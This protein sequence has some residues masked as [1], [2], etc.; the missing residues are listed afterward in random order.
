MASAVKAK[1]QRVASGGFSGSNNP[2]AD[3]VETEKYKLMIT[4]GPSYD[5]ALH[6]VVRV[7]TDV[8]VYVENE[9]V[10]AKINVR[11][12][13]FHGLPSSSPQTSPYFNDPTHDKD[14]YSIGFSF[15]PKQD[16][17]SLDTVWGN[18]FDHPIRN[19]LPPGFNTA[20]RIVKEFVDP[21]LSCDA[22]ADEPWLYGP[23]L[24]CWFAMRIGDHYDEDTDFPAPADK[25][26]L[27]EGA[28][29]SG[30]D[31]RRKHGL[32]DTNEKRR[33]HFLSAQHRESFV[34]EKGRLYEGDFYNPYLD[35]PNFAL[36][37]PGFSLKVI[38]Y[39]D[40]KSH[41][42][43][44]VFKNRK[45]GD[46]YFNINFHLLWGD[47]LRQAVQEDEE[48]KKRADSR[49][50]APWRINQNLAGVLSAHSAMW[51]KG[52]QQ[53]QGAYANIGGAGATGDAAKADGVAGGQAQHH[54]GHKGVDT[55]ADDVD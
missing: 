55:S 20:F 36:K 3:D 45:T 51:H 7:N 9:Y 50:V 30:S 40:Q 11:I 52:T 46:V 28:S 13:G 31:V 25:D 41:C 47:Q 8:P 53:P 1:L 6:E 15:V 23:S 34:F 38:K 21:G 18:D 2:T 39:V 22:Y 4:A 26:P 42:L 33:K 10:R 49:G 16:L 5:Q 14:L 27:K 35:F 24:S 17:S 54:G 37:L 12:R 43:R 48:E 19:K 29:G 32:P 44:Y